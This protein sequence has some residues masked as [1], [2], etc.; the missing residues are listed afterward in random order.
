MRIRNHQR[1]VVLIVFSYKLRSLPRPSPRPTNPFE[2]PSPLSPCPFFSGSL[3]WPW[4]RIVETC[5][6][7]FYSIVPRRQWRSHEP[8]RRSNDRVDG[9]AVEHQLVVLL[10][11][12]R[13]STNL[14]LC[15]SLPCAQG[16]GPVRPRKSP[17]GQT[18]SPRWQ[19]PV[20]SPK[21]LR[22]P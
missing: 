20:S 8:R 13:H 15:E 18:G 1:V 22:A 5:D 4:H 7:R 16:L 14:Y 9:I 11:L 2:L 10:Q 21:T 17:R 6:F 19:S 3:V 12:L